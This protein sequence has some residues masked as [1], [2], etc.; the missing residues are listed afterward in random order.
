MKKLL[1][2]LATTLL[3]C[4]NAL[5]YA[6]DPAGTWRAGADPVT[7]APDPAT[8]RVQVLPA[9]N[10]AHLFVEIYDGSGA[11]VHRAETFGP[12]WVALNGMLPGVYVVRVCDGRGMPVHTGRLVVAL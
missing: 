4:G 2:T 5:V 11:M 6:Q 3:C 10:D 1:I 12:T 8:E 9:T 7:L